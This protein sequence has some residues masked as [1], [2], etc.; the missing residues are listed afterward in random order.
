MLCLAGCTGLLELPEGLK[1]G[2]DIKLAGCTALSKLPRG[3]EIGRGTRMIDLTNCAG[4]ASLPESIAELA[5]KGPPEGL[6][7]LIAGTSIPLDN[8]VRIR[9]ILQ[10]RKSDGS[11]DS[12]LRFSDTD[13]TKLTEVGKGAQTGSSNSMLMGVHLSK[14]EGLDETENMLVGQGERRRKQ[15]NGKAATDRFPCVEALIAPFIRMANIE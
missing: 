13:F 11:N 7:I 6:D 8:I 3:L 1:V 12:Y 4:I 10:D 9:S 14:T 15:Q 5:Q 2:G